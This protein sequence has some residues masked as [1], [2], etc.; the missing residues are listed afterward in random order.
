MRV[1]ID[2]TPLVGPRTGVGRFVEALL[3]ALA[4]RGDV[5]VEPYVLSRRARDLPAGTKRVLVPAALALR[6]W[7]RGGPSLAQLFPHAEVIHGTNQIAPPTAHTV[8]TVNDC[9]FVTAR[10]LCSPTVV[11]FGPVVRR[12]AASG[13]W[14][15]AISEHVAVQARALFE[16]DRVVAVPLGPPRPRPDT[17]APVE[18]AR[19]VVAIGTLEP[20]KNFPRLVHAFRAVAAHDPEVTLT[21]AGADGPDSEQVRSAIGSL[22]SKMRARV[23]LTGWIDDNERDRLLEKA[24]VLAF[25]SLDE[26]FGFPMLE[27]WQ[28]EVPVVAARA[29]ALPEI[30]GDAALLVDPFDVD[31]LA[32]ALQRA[33][34]DEAERAALVDR[35]LARLATFSW[36]ATAE[37]I[38]A[39]YRRAMEDKPR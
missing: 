29:G 27:A 14:I 34:D 18:R 3:P 23:R 2:A 12:V 15:H 26:G 30:A 7:G 1:A 25:P 33:L 17:S 11:S 35:G 19:S 16:T 20:R 4:A 24:T 22:D 32:D 9:S 31:A 36:E 8:V 13:G 37:G 28:C 6:S 10:E 21:I 38:A 5:A 39:I